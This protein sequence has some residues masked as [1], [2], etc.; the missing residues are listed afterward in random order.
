MKEFYG[1]FYAVKLH[2][3]SKFIAFLSATIRDVT[4]GNAVTIK[5]MIDKYGVNIRLYELTQEEYV[6]F[7]EDKSVEGLPQLEEEVLRRGSLRIE[8]VYTLVPG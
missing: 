8:Y 5:S 6:A 2:N 3:G 7:M 1:E 4:T